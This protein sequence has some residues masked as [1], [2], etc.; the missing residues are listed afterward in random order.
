[1]MPF[2]LYSFNLG[3]NFLAMWGRG[4]VLQSVVIV[5]WIPTNQKAVSRSHDHEKGG[6]SQ[7]S[8]K[9]CV[10]TR[11]KEKAPPDE[12]LEWKRMWK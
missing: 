5:A 6:A 1:M 11:R 7:E 9:G 8:C 12:F 4:G 10:L 2:F 3:S